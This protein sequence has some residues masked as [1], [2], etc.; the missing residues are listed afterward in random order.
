M[1][2][3]QNKISLRT[4]FTNKKSGTPIPFTFPRKVIKIIFLLLFL[5][6]ASLTSCKN[7]KQKAKIGILFGHY[8]LKQ[9]KLQKAFL[10]NKI[11][12]L[13]AIPIFKT[14]NGNEIKQKHLVDELIKDD[15]DVLIIMVINLNNASSIVRKAHNKNIKVI[16]YQALIN[17][18]QS[19]CYISFD[20]TKIGEAMA[21]Y[22]TNRVPKGNYII[23][24]GASGNQNSINIKKGIL[25][26]LNKNK[27][28]I[29]YSAFTETWSE[30]ESFYYTNKA[31]QF[32]DENID[33]IIAPYSGLAFG[34]EKAVTK[35][36]L[37]GKILVTGHTANKWTCKQIL[38]GEDIFVI[39]KSPKMIAEKAAEIAIKLANNETINFTDSVFN[40]KT[41]VP[42]ILLDPIIITQ[43]NIQKYIFDEG[44]IDK[45]KVI[46]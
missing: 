7:D 6:L 44:Y 37:K 20:H 18:A 31:I 23:F 26:I 40:G 30:K 29:V 4:T 45:E 16:A 13:G 21:K 3:Q 41:K 5:I 14:A 35:N 27:V 12:E 34:A 2:L 11:K 46:N 19:D 15:I 25:N 36:G 42:S 17:N 38:K 33:A 39:H 9:W 28:N 22:S 10:E 24:W 43:K 1:L 32:S 8:N